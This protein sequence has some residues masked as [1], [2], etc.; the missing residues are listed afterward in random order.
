MAKS[1]GTSVNIITHTE[2]TFFR[3]FCVATCALLTAIPLSKRIVDVRGARSLCLWAILLA[4]WF[5]PALLIS[6]AYSRVSLALGT[7]PLLLELFYAGMLFLRFVPIATLAICFMPSPL[8]DEATH[9]HRLLRG[10]TLAERL[11]FRVLGAGPGPWI[12]FAVVFVLTFS[13]FELASLWNATTW[14]IQLFDAQAGGSVLSEAARL[15]SAPFVCE[16]LILLPT[17]VLFRRTLLFR[18]KARPHLS[19]G[20]VAYLSAAAILATVIPLLFVLIQS[21]PGWPALAHSTPLTEIAVS[22]L[23][24]GAA[25]AAAFTLAAALQQHRAA[26]LALALPGLMGALLVS[27]LLLAFFQFPLLRNIYDTPIPL[28]A[29]L[30]LIQFPLAVLLRMI[31]FATRPAAAL[32]LAHLLKSRELVWHLESRRIFYVVFLLFCFGYFD[33]TAAS[34]LAPIGMTPILVRLHNLAHYGQTAVLSAMLCAAFAVP[35]V[36]LW[37]APWCDAFISRS[38]ERGCSLETRRSVS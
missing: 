8:A 37:L 36:L 25:T 34:I 1:G 26:L 10:R 28:L 24:A 18:R 4:P 3:S 13:E 11:R 38:C 6:Y 7:I 14:T 2:W 30:T 31:M 17:F 16:L 23:F 20:A 9:C 35:A 22:I 29:A 21:L 5:T 32:H 27:L 12:T 33:F 19:V 15:A